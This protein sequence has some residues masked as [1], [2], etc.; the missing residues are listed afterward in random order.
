[1]IFPQ[2]QAKLKSEKNMYHWRGKRKVQQT[3]ELLVK[4]VSLQCN[5]GIVIVT[6]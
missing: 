3:G 6:T 4:L 2:K 1:M 5:K